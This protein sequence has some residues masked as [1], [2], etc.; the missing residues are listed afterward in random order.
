[1]GKM[2]RRAIARR[3]DCSTAVGAVS[4]RELTRPE[5]GLWDWSEDQVKFVALSDA[6]KSSMTRH[7]YDMQSQT[8]CCPP[9]VEVTRIIEVKNP[10]RQ[11]L[12][13]AA[14]REMLQRNPN[15]CPAIPDMTAVSCLGTGALAVPWL[16]R[17]CQRADSQERL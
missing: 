5:E 7:R 17:S 11:E 2:G 13:E 9:R 4:E 3:P 10:V 6:F 1:M 16:L 8:W 15:G 12:Y 14:R